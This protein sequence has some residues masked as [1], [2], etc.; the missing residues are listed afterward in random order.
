MSLSNI[1]TEADKPGGNGWECIDDATRQLITHIFPAP[2]LGQI[3]VKRFLERAAQESSVIPDVAPK[4]VYI[5]TQSIATLGKELSL[6]NDTTQKYV[7]LF[8]ALGLLQKQKFLGRLAFVLQIG[9]YHAPETLEANLDYLIHYSRPKLR[10]MAVD[11][12]TRC[13]L[14]GLIAQDIHASFEQ[15]Q[16]LLSGTESCTKR[17]LLQKIAQARVLASTI[18]TS[19]VEER[20]AGTKICNHIETPKL[21]Q[22]NLVNGAFN[23]HSQITC[24]LRP[25]KYKNLHQS[26]QNLPRRNF[27]LEVNLRTDP[28]TSTHAIEQTYGTQDKEQKK[29]TEI[30]KAGDVSTSLSNSTDTNLPQ[31]SN[32]VDASIENKTQATQETTRAFKEYLQLRLLAIHKQESKQSDVEDE[33]TQNVAMNRFITEEQ[34]KNPPV[35]K[36]VVDSYPPEANKTTWQEAVQKSLHGS[37]LRSNLPKVTAHIDVSSRSTKEKSTPTPLISRQINPAHSNRSIPSTENAVSAQMNTPQTSTQQVDSGRFSNKVPQTDVPQGAYEVDSAPTQPMQKLTTSHKDSQLDHST[38]ASHLSQMANEVD[39][40]DLER[41]VNVN[42]IYNFFITFTLRNPQQVAIFLAEQFEQDQQAYPKYRKLFSVQDG[43]VRTPQVLL[44]AYMCTMVR[45]YRDKWNITSRPGGFFTMRCREFDT[46]I[47]QEV[48]D[49]IKTYGHLSATQLV[50]TLAREAVTPAKS[51]TPMPKQSTPV[52]QPEVQLDP[53]LKIDQ[54]AITMTRE[55]A[56]ALIRK[57]YEDDKLTSMFRICL[58]P[59]MHNQNYAILID[60]SI[61]GGTARQTVVY[62]LEEWNK[63]IRNKR[64]LKDGVYHSPVQP[65]SQQQRQK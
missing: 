1:Q 60:M 14:Y 52:H 37:T 21:S 9:T 49:W 43:Q 45:L 7:K 22:Q 34:K 53:S 6:S 48:E 63:R 19:V 51:T 29:I 28:G 57:I 36:R 32:R 50:E 41:N 65:L 16:T 61:P 10:A 25:I 23:D 40:T 12:K 3:F 5:C 47:P 11:V 13:K 2:T 20:I 38:E 26:L 30:A 4:S 39:S 35:N 54:A 56:E 31:A 64:S 59:G 62:S 42:N 58:L 27:W 15:L 33:S 18:H 46:S 55:Q 8:M 24:S 17:F 44:A